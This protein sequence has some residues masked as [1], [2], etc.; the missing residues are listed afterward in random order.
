MLT[1]RRKKKKEEEE[2]EEEE[3]R[4]KKLMQYKTLPRCT[5]RVNPCTHGILALRSGVL[6]SFLLRAKLQ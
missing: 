5:D 3:E 2:E 6:N 4:R 1:D